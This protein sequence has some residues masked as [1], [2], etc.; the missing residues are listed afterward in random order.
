MSV[1]PT[2]RAW[3]SVKGIVY[4]TPVGPILN[5]VVHG[6]VVDFIEAT[7]QAEKASKTYKVYNGGL[8]WLDGASAYFCAAVTSLI[9]LVHDLALALFNGLAA[10]FSEQA[11]KNAKIYLLR[12]AIDGTVVIAGCVG[13]VYTPKGA[14]ATATWLLS[15]APSQPLNQLAKALSVVYDQIKFFPNGGWIEEL[16]DKLQEQ[17]GS[18]R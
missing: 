10:P 9:H 16:T 12:S 4:N 8:T 11:K 2:D 7:V 15:Q 3:E 18:N 13:T 1:T 14:V 6:A 5:T 17:L